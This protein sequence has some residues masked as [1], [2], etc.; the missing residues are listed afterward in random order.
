LL[1]AKEE[2]KMADYYAAMTALR[3]DII[4]V[5]WRCDRDK[6]IYKADLMDYLNKYHGTNFKMSATKG[7]MVEKMK[8]LL[9]ASKLEHF[10]EHLKNFGIVKNDV[11]YVLHIGKDNLEKLIDEGTIRQIG[12]YVH[13]EYK[14][15][16]HIMSVTDVI[17]YYSESDR[18]LL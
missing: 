7:E 12:T 14:T 18:W 6:M 9:T 15:E 17:N 1:T 8:E 16:Y 13:G 3:C 10:E 2:K 11:R 4:D 5:Y